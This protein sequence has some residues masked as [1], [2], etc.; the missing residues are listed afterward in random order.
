MSI[1]MGEQIAMTHTEAAKSGIGL[2]CNAGGGS[3]HR[4]LT[5]SDAGV[6]V[7]KHRLDFEAVWKS[8]PTKEMPPESDRKFIA[9]GD[10][11]VPLPDRKIPC[12]GF[13]LTYPDHRSE[14]IDAESF[15]FVKEAP[16]IANSKAIPYRE[17]LDYELEIGL[18]MHRNA[19]GRFGYFL[20]ND[21]TDRGVQVENYDAKDPAPGF[22]KA[23]SFEGALRAGPLLAI[24]D[25]SAWPMMS[26]S[27]KLNGEVRQT[28]SAENCR[29]DPEQVH[30]ELF[31]DHPDESWL[32]V[33]TGTSAGTLFRVP[34]TR[35]KLKALVAGKFSMKRA[36][37]VWLNSL[38][39]LIPGDKIV[40]QSPILGRSEARLEEE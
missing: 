21:L 8:S 6:V 26:A 14:T 17:H 29:L 3:W 1:R 24:G 22:G 9:W 20:A 27:L 25:A 4:V 30:G 23:K 32:V 37:Q 36:G 31:A 40:L 2:Y 15:R 19:P 12:W 34:Q 35:E 39:F 33:A 5:Q 18:L 16:P 10:L 38:R 28:L 11:D 7:D 13:A